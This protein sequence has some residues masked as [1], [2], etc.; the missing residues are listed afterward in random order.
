[1]HFGSSRRYYVYETNCVFKCFVGSGRRGVGR[2]QQLLIIHDAGAP[3]LA[4]KKGIILCSGAFD[5]EEEEVVVVEEKK[6]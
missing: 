2:H 6:Y 3:T 1:M 5:V 4:M